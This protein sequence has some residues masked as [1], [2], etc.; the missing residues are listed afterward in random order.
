MTSRQSL[1]AVSPI[2][3]RHSSWDEVKCTVVPILLGGHPDV[4]LEKELGFQR[5]LPG[6]ILVNNM[7]Y[8]WDLSQYE[9]L[10]PLHSGVRQRNEGTFEIGVRPSVSG[11][12]E[13]IMHRV[14][15]PDP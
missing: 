1:I 2:S 6:A 10:A 11:N 8:F 5:C 15:R 13:V 9:Y 3:L 14:F 7:T 4:L 12:T